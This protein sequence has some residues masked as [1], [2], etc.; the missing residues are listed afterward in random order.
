MQPVHESKGSGLRAA[1][2]FSRPTSA[3]KSLRLGSLLSAGLF[4]WPAGS[5]LLA[6]MH[7][8][9]GGGPS[10]SRGRLVVNYPVLLTVLLVLAIVAVLLVGYF[11]YHR[12][13]RSEGSLE[14]RVADLEKSIS[15]LYR[16]QQED[17]DGVLRLLHPPTQKGPDEPGGKTELE[18]DTR[19]GQGGNKGAR[20]REEG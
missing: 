2:A 14:R 11:L 17:L 1:F 13:F 16:K 19:V 18:Q 9:Y 3:V 5:G 15:A 7:P 10:G 12:F 4:Y 8:G 6:Q 20:N